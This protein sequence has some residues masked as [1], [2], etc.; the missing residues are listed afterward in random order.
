MLYLNV[1]TM[2]RLRGI[3]RPY[4][5]LLQQGITAGTAK[6]ILSGAHR[7]VSFDILEILCEQLRCTPNELIEWRATDAQAVAGHPLTEL[8]AGAHKELQDLAENLST[9]SV[10]ELRKLSRGAQ[11]PPESL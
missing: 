1:K 6:K 10:A 7:S 3:A 4:N 8:R 5:W 2:M 9:M 11:E